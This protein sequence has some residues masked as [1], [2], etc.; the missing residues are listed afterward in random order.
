MPATC[1]LG[2][3][4]GLDG[5]EFGV[6]LVVELA[7][8]TGPKDVGIDVLVEDGASKIRAWLTQKFAGSVV[9]RLTE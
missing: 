9:T 6:E 3:G 7:A 4:L 5:E 2:S 1:P 8:G